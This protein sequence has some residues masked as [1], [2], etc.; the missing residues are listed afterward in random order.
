MSEKVDDL[1]DLTEPL[2]LKA[3]IANRSWV[4]SNQPFPYVVAQDVFVGDVY[5]RLT[6][7]FNELLAQGTFRQQD[8]NY[9]ALM[10][11]MPADHPGALGIFVSR[12]WRDVL[13]HLFGR[14]SISGVSVSLHHHERGS[15][16]GW[17]HNDLSPA[18]FARPDDPELTVTS[19]QDGVPYRSGQAPAGVPVMAAA[20]S[21]SILY[22]LANAQWRPGD[23]GE[24]GLFN[25]KRGIKTPTARMPP[26]NNSLLAFECSPYSFHAYQNNHRS[27]RNAVVM[28]LHQSR[29]KAEEQWGAGSLV[30]WR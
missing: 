21:I 6:A 14:E 30:E 22:Y 2:D 10:Y 13:S 12:A 3:L 17:I 15:G 1:K 9:G 11:E 23:G 19:G 4:R 25:G 7:E 20:R 8:R 29:Q 24:T 28:W 26:V 5:D 18:W 16:D 27:D